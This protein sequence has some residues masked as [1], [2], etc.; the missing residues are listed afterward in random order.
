MAAA[1]F[2]LI[3]LRGRLVDIVL[4]RDEN[5]REI[6]PFRILFFADRFRIVQEPIRK[7]TKTI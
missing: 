3:L 6:P 7:G 2:S 5:G 4:F 1:R